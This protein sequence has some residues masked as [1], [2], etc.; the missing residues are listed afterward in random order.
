MDFVMPWFQDQRV[1]VGDFAQEER[2]GD[3]RG[4]IL[5]ASVA[6]TTTLAAALSTV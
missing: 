2:D 3:A 5:N 1:Q 4:G 6:L